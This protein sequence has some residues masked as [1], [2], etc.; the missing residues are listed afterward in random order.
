MTNQLNVYAKG[1]KQIKKKNPLYGEF[2]ALRD[3]L[4]ATDGVEGDVTVVSPRV[5][6]EEAWTL[7]G[8]IVES[9]GFTLVPEDGFERVVRLPD[10]AG[11]PGMGALVPEDGELPAHGLVT[12]VLH[13]EHVPAVEMRDLLEGLVRRKDAVSVLPETNHLVVSDTAETVRRVRDLLAE[14]LIKRRVLPF[15]NLGERNDNVLGR[16]V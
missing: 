6:R 13:V 1:V 14:I 10:R 11:G 4:G 15:G 5:S 2:A 7:F 8:S 16:R 12:A 3:Y 9:C